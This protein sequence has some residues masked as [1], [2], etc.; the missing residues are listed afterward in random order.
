MR[1]SDQTD[2]RATRR[3]STD[4]S[5]YLR[6]EE[7]NYRKL[8]AAATV[9]LD[10]NV[11]LDLYELGRAPRNEVMEALRGLGARLWVPY[12]A[13]LEFSRNR[14]TTVR[15]RQGKYKAIALSL[16]N[17]PE[18]A[19]R[20]LYK[21]VE[22]LI[23]LRAK[24]RTTHDWLPQAH[25]LTKDDLT[26]M[27]AGTINAAL[28]EIDRLQKEQDVTT[29]AV[30][31]DDHLFLEVDELLAG[32]I[33]S[34]FP[35]N[36]LRSHV[37]EAVSF[38]FPNEIPPGY[39]DAGK[40]T[41]LLAAGDYLLWRQVIEHVRV[42]Q[43][44]EMAPVVL[45]TSE[46]KGDW[47]VLKDG[48]STGAARPELIHELAEEASA[49]LI[50]LS[51][52]E[53]VR[54]AKERP[55]SH[56]SDDTVEQLREAATPDSGQLI[57]S[58]LSSTELTALVGRLIRAMGFDNVAI[59]RSDNTKHAF[60]TAGGNGRRAVVG[61]LIDDTRRHSMTEFTNF[62]EAAKLDGHSDVIA[63]VALR[64]ARFHVRKAAREANVLLMD[65]PRRYGALESE[66]GIVAA[67]YEPI[68]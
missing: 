28:E 1:P 60:A 50:L 9:V 56:I 41:D 36:E 22:R 12:Q 32:K 23:E 13:A 4:F 16:R 14:T 52:A 61:L 19:A 63:Y 30:H 11:L 5:G 2:L 59:L 54:L 33:G 34:P 15:N 3:L 27:L 6:P 35:A 66:L 17:A 37:E 10:A 53:F 48:E 57:L 18:A 45:V 44:H 20:E 21:P 49:S 38:R 26:K 43:K 42:I 62:L 46:R 58:S 39:D 25:S 24:A 65:G 7:L 40:P 29:E 68:P 51:L 67:P 8:D 55:N 64:P 47:W 31:T